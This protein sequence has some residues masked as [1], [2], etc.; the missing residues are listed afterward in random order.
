MLL[1]SSRYSLLI[2]CQEDDVETL[3]G[4]LDDPNHPEY[5]PN[6]MFSCGG[7]FPLLYFAAGSGSINVTRE[8]VQRGANV[9]L[10]PAFDV[11]KGRTPLHAAAP[12]HGGWG[13]ETP[14]EN[15]VEVC[16]ILLEAGADPNAQITSWA[17]NGVAPLHYAA[18]G[19]ANTNC[20]LLLKYG[21]D[22]N[23]C[24][25]LQHT[26]LANAVSHNRVET[27]GLLVEFGA[28]PSRVAGFMGLKDY[29]ARTGACQ[30]KE[31]TEMRELVAKL[32]GE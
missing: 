16:E 9:D 21:A 15:F 8:L 23:M 2:A 1:V 3:V 31:Y 14:D 17:Y 29:V 28:D 18:S 12:G 22:P 11:N 7:W 24:D 26:P 30:R 20:M 27:V 32:C 10:A 13:T 4:M 25:E 6:S 5:T 19:G